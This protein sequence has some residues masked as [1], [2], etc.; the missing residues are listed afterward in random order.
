MVG[1][2]SWYGV[3]QTFIQRIKSI[4]NAGFDSTSIWIGEDNRR[5][6]DLEDKPSIIKDCGLI[7]EYA[8]APYRNINNLW[9][10]YK[11]RETELEIKRHIDYCS[12][13]EIPILV[14]HLTKGYRIKEANEYGLIVLRRLIEYAKDRKVR[15][16]A[17]NTKQNNVL[18]K[19]FHEIED[20]VLGLCFDTSH[21]NLYSDLKFGIIEKYRE[22]LLCLH[23]SDND[24][25]VDDHW[26]PYQGKID[27]EAFIHRFPKEYGGILNLEILPKEKTADGDSLLAEAYKVIKKIE[28]DIHAK[29]ESSGKAG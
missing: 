15:I 4:K 5:E 14:V 24:G 18:E 8:H 3:P 13:N 28:I 19:V 6:M 20:P 17:E 22:R 25:R 2:F 29:D 9:D 21:D 12:K 27:W 1:I 16:A 23:I 10:K 7:L 11:S 26:I